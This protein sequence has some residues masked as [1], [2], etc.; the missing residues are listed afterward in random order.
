MGDVLTVALGV[1]GA[2]VIGLLRKKDATV[3]K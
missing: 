3:K 1:V 2:G